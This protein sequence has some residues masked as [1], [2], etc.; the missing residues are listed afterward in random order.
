MRINVRCPPEPLAAE[1]E[2]R[3][4]A[5]RGAAGAGARERAAPRRADRQRRVRH[6]VQG[7]LDPRRPERQDPR[8]H[9]GMHILLLVSELDLA[10]C[11]A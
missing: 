7:P 9:Q 11:L 10:P 5:G 6:R 2:P 3:R 4:A 8:R 1:R